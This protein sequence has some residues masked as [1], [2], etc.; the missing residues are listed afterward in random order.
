[1]YRY[2]TEEALAAEAPP[3]RDLL[4]RLAPFDQV[5]AGLVD[6]LGLTPALAA[7]GT[8]PDI[9]RQGL[10]LQTADRPGWFTV[11]AVARTVLTDR[12]PADPADLEAGA[13]WLEEQGELA[14]AL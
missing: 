1:L 9:A 10:W 14:Q 4:E 11:P 8:L 6:A 7:A 12:G 13:R 5:H 3:V 2:L